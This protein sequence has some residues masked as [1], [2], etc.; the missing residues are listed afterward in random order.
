MPWTGIPYPLLLDV[1]SLEL[2]DQQ[3]EKIFSD[4]AN[5]QFELTAKGELVIIAPT[6]DPG[7]YRETRLA[8]RVDIWAMQGRYRCCFGSVGWVQIA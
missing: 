1:S 8:T 5:P 3:L 2:T 6:G 4:N 7:S